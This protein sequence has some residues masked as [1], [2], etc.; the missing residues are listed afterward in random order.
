[1]GIQKILNPAPSLQRLA[2]ASRDTGCES[3]GTGSTDSADVAA[4]V[5]TL[6]DGSKVR[7][8]AEYGAVGFWGAAEVD[9]DLGHPT[10]TGRSRQEAL[11]DLRDQLNDKLDEVSDGRRDC[12]ERRRDAEFAKAVQRTQV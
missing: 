4:E 10:G 6:S 11:D 3:T 8:I 1:M 12:D 9:Y 5:L 2:A 7:C